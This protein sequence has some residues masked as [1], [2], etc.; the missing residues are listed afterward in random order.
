MSMEKMLAVWVKA[1]YKA[2][3]NK[4]GSVDVYVGRI[5]GLVSAIELH[6]P[7]TYSI[8]ELTVRRVTSEIINPSEGLFAGPGLMVFV[9]IGLI[10]LMW[11]DFEPALGVSIFLLAAT[12]SYFVFVLFVKLFP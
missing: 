9:V 4:A 10:I 3:I 7:C 2:C 6:S 11:M 5:F 12:I 1:K 8:R